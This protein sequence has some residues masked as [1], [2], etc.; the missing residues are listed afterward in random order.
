MRKRFLA[1]LLAAGMVLQSFSLPVFAAGGEQVQTEVASDGAAEVSFE[2]ESEKEPEAVSL[3]YAP[4]LDEGEVIEE[5][6]SVSEE[7]AETPVS[8]PSEA[9]ESSSPAQTEE[10]EAG[11]TETLEEE[12]GTTEISEGETDGLQTQLTEEFS[13]QPDLKGEENLL[14]ETEGQEGTSELEIGY[15]D[16]GEGVYQEGSFTVIGRNT[17]DE[18]GISLYAE[19]DLSEAEDYLYQQLLKKEASID[20]SKYEIPVDMASAF[21]F[22]VINDHPDL[23]FARTSFGYRYNPTTSTLTSVSVEFIEGLD[24]AAFNQAV[25]EAMSVIEDGMTDLEKAI[26][27]HEYIVLN[28][29]YDYENYLNNSIPKASYSAYGVMVN[30]TAVCQGYALAY[31]LLLN[32]AG[33][34]CYMV[35]SDAMTHAWNLIQLDGQ[36]YQVD[37]TW[38]DPTWDKFGLVH[39]SYMFVSDRAFSDTA[40]TVRDNHYGGVITKGS[41]EV[42]LAA[43]DSRYDNVFWTGNSSPLVLA[44]HN[45]YYIDSDS[46][47]ICMK[48]SIDAEPSTIVSNIGIWKTADGTGYWR[49]A[50]S[51][52]FMIDDRLYFNTP[53]KIC[54]VSMTGGDKRDETDDLNSSSQ[55]VYSS[56]LCQGKVQYVLHE[57]PNFSGKETILTANLKNVTIDSIALN[58]A[59]VGIASGDTVTLKVILTPSYASAKEIN[60]T[61]SDANIATVSNGVVT[62]VGKEGSCTI[63]A[64]AGGKSAVCTV[65]IL[66][67]LKAPTFLPEAGLIDKGEK[68][69]LSAETDAEIYY[70][71]DGSKPDIS[72]AGTE[73]YTAPIIINED[74]TIR[75]I[76]V[77]PSGIYG[78]STIATAEYQ[79]CTNHLILE[80][81]SVTIAKGETITLGIIELP[82]TK[83]E[84]DVT[85]TSSDEKIVTAAAGGKLTAVSE[86]EAVVTATVEDYKGRT[87]TAACDVKVDDSEYQVTFIGWNNEVVKTETVKAGK[88]ATPPEDLTSPEGYAFKGWK[89]D[90]S[91]ISQN[92]T[93]EAMFEPIVYTITYQLNGGTNAAGNPADYTIETEDITL[94]PAGGKDGFLFVG[95][96][97]DEKYKNRVETI[98][99]GS[100][101]NITLYARWKDERGLWLKAEGSNTENFIPDEPY[102]GKAVKPAVEVYYGSTPLKAGTDYTISYKNNTAANLLRTDAEKGKAPTVVIKGKGNYA[103]TLTQT[104]VITPKSIA[105]IEGE[106]RKDGEVQA[107]DLAAAYN[108]GREV[109]P[110]PVLVWNGKKLSNKKDFTVEYPDT[111]ADAYK[112][113]GS[114]KVRI[115]GKGNFTGTREI[116]LTIAD[117]DNDILMS[118]VKISK[119]PEQP[120]TGSAAVFGQDMPKLAYKGEVLKLNGDYTLSLAAGDDGVSAGSHVLV[121][122]GLGK[123]KG[124]RRVNFKIKGTP[125]NTVT[126]NGLKSLVYNGTEQSF[127]GNS[128]NKLTLTDR[129]G[130]TLT[131]DRDYTLS[132]S[133]NK[134]VGTAKVTITG[135]GKYSGK[136]T[137]SFK[138]T[139]YS[140]A[141]GSTGIEAVF[142]NSSTEQ[143]YEKGGAKP[144]VKVTFRGM[145]L[146]EGTDYTLSYTNNTS[147]APKEGKVPTVTVKGKKNF[148]GSR[149]ITFTIK[150]KELD[151]TSISITAPDLEENTKAGKYMSVPVLTDSNGKKLKAGTDY[152]KT[153]V[154]TDENGNVLEKTDKPLKGSILTVTVTGKGNYTGSTSTSFRILAKGMSISK[155]SAKVNTKVY[156]TGEEIELTEKDLTVK[157]GGTTLTGNDFEI[158]GY[159]N[160]I[161]KGTAKVTIRGKGKYGGT[162]QVSFKI[163]SQNMQWWSRK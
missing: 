160:N 89:G 98:K 35:T 10:G 62:A 3:E 47:S 104:F 162:K 30:R 91:S 125:V 48:S 109:K 41:Y 50:F 14:Q 22:G 158:V 67:R 130:S 52:L 28:C 33:I 82:T 16:G 144:K 143:P 23:Y 11:E 61:T 94:K 140:V 68:V 5:T 120:Y 97:S 115:T 129:D 37:P 69:T 20:V 84:T 110:V 60:W 71:L 100:K 70:T 127:G 132:F 154:Y 36:Y 6:S 51:G 66:S 121:I 122:T 113:P 150:A 137:K 17:E 126:V 7:A 105:P 101:G 75:A 77:D 135:I 142:E 59:A 73:K 46:N 39:H 96:Y 111:N 116:M 18:Y 114:Y 83:K 34:E 117:P 149:P 80:K 99:K 24:D 95:W 106:G 65:T 86:G 74:T 63:T 92:T 49:G 58:P 78:N 21:V 54:S 124:V 152:E 128:G 151:D 72:G 123:Y 44:D 153:Y 90:Y 88:A 13:V 145:E 1:G 87:V 27:L 102:T 43:E 131:E 38:D 64:E 93:I 40:S 133:N 138:I 146:E 31:K 119:I 112:A 45:Y 85:W 147:V 148:T 139:A 2:E 26:A 9:S 15:V 136:L 156:Y 108:R 56:A 53:Y 29:E 76:A 157:L 141:E 163:L 42:N 79:V 159:S 57:D 134:N 25:E 8:A 32:K 55:Y 161:K 107:D 4:D 103:G 19:I 118:K 155:A 81:E 12:S